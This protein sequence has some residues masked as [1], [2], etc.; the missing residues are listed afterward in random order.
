MARLTPAQAALL[1]LIRHCQGMALDG[2]REFQT[3]NSLERRGLIR[4]DVNGFA[5]LSTPDALKGDA[6]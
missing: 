5:T 4:I 2:A 6:T 1:D 3:A